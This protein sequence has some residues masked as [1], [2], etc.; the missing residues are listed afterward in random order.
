MERLLGFVKLFNVVA[1]IVIVFGTVALVWLMVQRGGHSRAE[2]EAV[3]PPPPPV[4][5]RIAGI[6]AHADGLAFLVDLPDGGQEIRLLGANG[7]MSLLYRVA[8]KR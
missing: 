4:A 5:G 7:K 2:R 6:A 3:P 1:G 8:G